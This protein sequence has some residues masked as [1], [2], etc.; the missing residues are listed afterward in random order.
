MGEQ[1]YSPASCR[2]QSQELFLIT[3]GFKTD[4]IYAKLTGQD[5]KQSVLEN[6][7]AGKEH[8]PGKLQRTSRA[9]FV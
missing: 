9:S 2:E 5:L 1:H 7:V 3:F 6:A 8:Y 4:I